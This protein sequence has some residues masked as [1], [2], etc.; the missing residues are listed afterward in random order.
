MTIST[1]YVLW[2]FHICSI[3]WIFSVTRNVSVFQICE[4]SSEK[5]VKQD[6]RQK[7]RAEDTIVRTKEKIA[8]ERAAAAEIQ[9]TER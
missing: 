1:Q 3:V 9:T 8:Q 2:I 5:K 7:N 4:I 6:E